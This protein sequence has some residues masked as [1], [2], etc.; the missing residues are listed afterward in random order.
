LSET[1]FGQTFSSARNQTIFSTHVMLS[2]QNVFNLLYS[3]SKIA[4]PQYSRVSY[5]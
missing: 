3:I 5:K 1:E 4:L 2:P